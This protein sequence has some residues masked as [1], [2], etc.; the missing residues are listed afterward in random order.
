MERIS[1]RLAPLIDAA[2]V[3]PTSARWSYRASAG[4]VALL[5]LGTWAALYVVFALFTR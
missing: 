2:R 3:K 5:C 4:L 1:A